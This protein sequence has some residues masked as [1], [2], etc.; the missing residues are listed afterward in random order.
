[1]LDGIKK[2]CH[3]DK[4]L[5][6]LNSVTQTIW[7]PF[8]IESWWHSC[9]PIAPILSCAGFV[10]S[11]QVSAMALLLS[12]FFFRLNFDSNDQA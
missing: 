5:W 6:Y 10:E 3:L 9:L 2:L 7:L 12:L 8:K 1:M 4:N 11:M